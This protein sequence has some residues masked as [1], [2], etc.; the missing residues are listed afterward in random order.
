MYHPIAKI[1]KSWKNIFNGN[2][3]VMCICGMIT[4]GV[5]DEQQTAIW[6]EQETQLVAGELL[7]VPICTLS[8]E[9]SI[10]DVH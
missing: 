7:D 3:Q 10:A 8:I 4:V 5:Y 6:S 2:L 1:W 9:I